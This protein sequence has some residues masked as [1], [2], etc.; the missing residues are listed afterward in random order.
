MKEFLYDFFVRKNGRVQ[1]EYERYVR[2]HIDEHYL[3]RLRHL[4]L[5]LQL[6]WFYRLGYAFS[7][8]QTRTKK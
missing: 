4:R 5:L 7:G 1:Y 3:H 2:E 6:N 8:E